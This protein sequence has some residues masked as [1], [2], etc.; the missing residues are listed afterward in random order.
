ME[1]LSTLGSG[2]IDP[3]D[4]EVRLLCRHRAA[5]SGMA[6]PHRR[7]RHDPDCGR[8][9]R[10]SAKPSMPAYFSCLFGLGTGIAELWGNRAGT[11]KHLY[12]QSKPAA[13]KPNTSSRPRRDLCRGL[14]KAKGVR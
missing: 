1:A 11:R 4:H 9:V 3:L 12:W 13:D 8:N 5:M 14:K 7:K 6:G 10:T 2:R